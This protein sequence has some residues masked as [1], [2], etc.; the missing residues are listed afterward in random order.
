MLSNISVHHKKKTRYR[1][2]GQLVFQFWEQTINAK[3]FI[4][5]L[6]C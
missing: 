4:V 6:V 5:M 2:I 3:P 1:Y